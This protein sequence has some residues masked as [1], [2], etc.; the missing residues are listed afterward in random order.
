MAQVAMHFD[1]ATHVHLGLFSA[2][3]VLVEDFESANIVGRSVA[4]EVDAAKFAFAEGF[5]NFKQPE[6]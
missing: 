2:D 3:F 1:L 6:M 5:A 4:D